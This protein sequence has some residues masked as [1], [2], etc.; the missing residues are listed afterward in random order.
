MLSEFHFLLYIL[1]VNNKI[2]KAIYPN[3]EK[4]LV[5]AL[6]LLVKMVQDFW[7]LSQPA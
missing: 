4:G 2:P 1:K 6:L 7:S 5:D 3:W